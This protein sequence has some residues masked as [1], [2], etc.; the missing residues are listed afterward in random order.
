MQRSRS[1]A[2]GLPG[3][4]SERSAPLPRSSSGCWS[5][6][7][8]GP[9]TMPSL[10]QHPGTP[11]APPSMASSRYEPPPKYPVPKKPIAK[12]FDHWDFILRYDRAKYEEEEARRNADKH[13]GQAEYKAQLDRQMDEIRGRRRNALDEKERDRQVMAS[14][15]ER[16]ERDEEAERQNEEAKMRKLKSFMSETQGTNER[17]RMRLE[18]RNKRDR[19]EL[20]ERLDAEDQI[21]RLRKAQDAERNRRRAAETRAMLKAT[22]ERKAQE[23]CDERARDKAMMERYMA[24]WDERERLKEKNIQDRLERMMAI[25]GKHGLLKKPSKEDMRLE[26]KAAMTK[27]LEDSD[28][29][30]TEM[31]RREKETRQK[32][33]DETRRALALQVTEKAE[34]LMREKEDMDSQAII[35]EAQAR[36]AEQ[37]DRNEI[38]KKRAMR[39]E[40]DKH[41]IMTMQGELGT[42]QEHKV[43]PHKRATEIAMNRAIFAQMAMEGFDPDK[44]S[45]LL[46]EDKP[47]GSRGYNLSCPRYE[48]EIHEL[49]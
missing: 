27:A 44:A 19:D 26:E 2:S 4:G 42:H 1:A 3:V 20:K 16:R 30:A 32:Q 9:A 21:D 37:K 48:G 33:K 38:G 22:V 5:S 24:D 6:P 11:L 45:Q 49:E 47:V 14:E 35:W 31:H 8:G 41:L 28:A 17:K 18:E 13:M 39:D 23:K 46:S 29:I 7:G 25:A 36:E 15:A 40:L 12:P 10:P 43:D 34:R